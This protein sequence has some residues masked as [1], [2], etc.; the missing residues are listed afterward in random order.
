MKLALWLTLLLAAI[1]GA[2]HADRDIVYA[3]RYYAP[4]RSHRTSHFHL[5]RINPDGTGRTQLT[6]GGREDSGPR[7]SPD[8]RHIVFARDAP[9]GPS[10]LC[11]V[12][13]CGGAV[14]ILMAR[15]D[16]YLY[17]W[18]PDSR[19]IIVMYD[20]DTGKNGQTTVALLDIKT[21]QARQLPGATDFFWSPDG[22]K[23]YVV[24]KTGDQI[25]TLKTG[26]VVSVADPL[27]HPVWLTNNTLTGRVDDPKTD[28]SFVRV[29][30]ASGH[31]RQR[32]SPRFPKSLPTLDGDPTE[33]WGLLFGIPRAQN[34]VV[35]AVNNHN[36]T[37]GVDFVFL[38]LFLPTS[39]MRFLADGQFLA[40]NESGTRFCTAPGRDTLPYSKWPD[41]TVRTVWAAPLQVG[42]V[43]G[44]KVKTISHGLV[45][46]IG[47][48]WRKKTP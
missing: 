48:D 1:S 8:G 47:A 16:Y 2:A 15:G 43:K 14:T 45:W 25:L 40:W 24:R 17:R 22:Q 46:V 33:S 41:G 36:S 18:S 27:D 6:F 26:A 35:Y 38:R 28:K 20:E 7:W 44:G 39:A 34:A 31:E 9:V 11:L 42:S 12:K 32:V 19:T 21:R 30:D 10:L 5:Y 37:V 29:I 13:A 3:A 4:P 23:A